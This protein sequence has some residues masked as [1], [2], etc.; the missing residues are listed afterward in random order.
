M[1]PDILIV[2][3]S[4]SLGAKLVEDLSPKFKILGTYFKHKM[5]NLIPLDIRDKSEVSNLFKRINPYITIITA[6]KTNVEECELNPSETFEINTEGVEN[7]V[8]NTK[9]KIIFYSTDNVFDG[10]KESYA[11]EDRRAPI[12]IY[13]QSKSLAEPIVL[14]RKDNLVCRSS[15]FYSENETGKYINNMISTLRKGISVKAPIDTEGNFT[16]IPDVSNATLN[17]LGKGQSG[18]YH[19]AGSGFYSL[20]D[21]AVKVAKVFEFDQSLVQKVNKDYFNHNVKRP[22]SPLRINKLERLGI[23]MKNLEEGLI[24]IKEFEDVRQRI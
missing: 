21:A 4:G 3:A 16:F 7:I 18:I 19:V 6:A 12:N 24:K 20:Y 8:A 10:S 15:R 22:S 11:E 1:N 14:S 5:S 9:G 13:G 23:K 2:G 17:L